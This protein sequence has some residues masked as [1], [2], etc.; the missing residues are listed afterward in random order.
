MPVD[1]Y[2]LALGGETAGLATALAVI[3]GVPLAW[4][5]QNRRFPGKRTVSAMVTAAIAIPA[6]LLCYYLLARLGHAWPITLIGMTAAGVASVLPLA[7]RQMRTSFA[8][9]NTSSG[10]A[11]RSLGVSEWHVFARVELPLVW[12]S[13]AGVAAWALARVILELAAAFWIGERGA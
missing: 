3:L 2:W 7:L 5:L 1:R 10:K 13:M 8:A 11:A 9:L 4:M 6:P 12:R